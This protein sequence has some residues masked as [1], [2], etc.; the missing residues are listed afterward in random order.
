M[1]SKKIIAMLALLAPATMSSL[2]SCGSTK[3]AT[4][5]MVNTENKNYYVS[6]FDISVTKGVIKSCKVEQTYT[7]S[8]WAQ[9]SADNISKFTEDELLTV[10]LSSTDTLTYAKYIQIGGVTWVGTLRDQTS[11]TKYYNHAE[12][13]RYSIP[14]ASTDNADSDLIRYISTSIGNDA[15]GVN[16]Q[17][18]Y[19][20]VASNDIKLLKVSGDT[21]TD[22]SVA[23][24]FPNNSYSLTS[25]ETLNDYTA[26]MSKLAEF[27]IDKKLNF[28]FNIQPEDDSVESYKSIRTSDLIDGKRYY[29]YNP[30]IVDAKATAALCAQYYEDDSLWIT[31]EG[32]EFQVVYLDSVKAVFESINKAFISVEYDSIK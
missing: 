31:I 15:V 14:N 12:Y 29:Q 22:S 27:F 4:T 1:K 3:D 32:V 2:S 20:A 13:V 16:A 25:N 8:V 30:K 7:P 24:V 10:K 5:Y 18:Y 23:P 19:D 28:T 9:V 17:V 26:A 11:E 6:K 21:Y